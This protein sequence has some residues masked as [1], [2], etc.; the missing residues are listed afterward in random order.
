MDQY[1]PVPVGIQ[2]TDQQIA[3][4]L[5]AVETATSPAGGHGYNASL[6]LGASNVM[7]S[8]IFSFNTITVGTTADGS[9]IITDIASDSGLVIDGALV[10]GIGIPDNTYVSTIVSDTIIELT[11]PVTGTNV[12]TGLVFTVVTEQRQFGMILN[13][14]FNDTTSL[15]DPLYVV[16]STSNINKSSGTLLQVEQHAVITPSSDDVAEIIQIVISF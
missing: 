15:I 5:S 13:P 9:N 8:L 11:N 10:S 1:I 2:R 6:E 12:G 7:L 4:E 16:D 14:L 3:V